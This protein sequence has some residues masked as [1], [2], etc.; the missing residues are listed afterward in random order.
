MRSTDARRG[1]ELGATEPHSPSSAVGLVHPGAGYTSTVEMAF[2]IT[3]EKVSCSRRNGDGEFGCGATLA[4]LVD[5]GAEVRYVAFSIATRSLPEGFPPDTL[6]REVREATAELG[7]PDSLLDVH[8]FE[9]RTF[10]EHRQEILE[11][12]IG[13]WE[14]W[15]P[16]AVLSEPRRHPPGS[17]SRRRGVSAFKRTTL[18]GYGSGEKIQIRI[19]A[20]VALDPS[21]GRKVGA[22]EV[23]IPQHAGTTTRVHLN[24]PENGVKDLSSQKFSRYTGSWSE[25]PAASRQGLSGHGI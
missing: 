21:R 20:T 15:K 8:D 16:D 1:G 23:R 25:P 11:L 19:P 22:L 17:G 14:E 6:A 18:L 10:P 7:I 13:L 2:V 3:L 5:G 12:L 9:V 24:S 4:R